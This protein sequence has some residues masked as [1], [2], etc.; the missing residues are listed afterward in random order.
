MMHELATSF[1]N[2]ITPLQNY[3]NSFLLHGDIFTIMS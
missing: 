3:L 1:Y 2:T